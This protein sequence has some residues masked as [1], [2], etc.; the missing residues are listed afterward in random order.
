MSDNKLD[1]PK[2]PDLVSFSCSCSQSVYDLV[3]EI[4]TLSIVT[5]EEEDVESWGW[6]KGYS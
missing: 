1:L 2:F 3:L 5:G 6:F 4:I